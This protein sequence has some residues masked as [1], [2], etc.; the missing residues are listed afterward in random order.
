MKNF[1]F[2]IFASVFFLA[3]YGCSEP[4]KNKSGLSEDTYEDTGIEPIPM[5]FPAGTNTIYKARADFYESVEPQKFVHPKKWM[6]YMAAT[7]WTDKGK[8]IVYRTSAD[9]AQVALVKNFIRANDLYGKVGVAWIQYDKN[10]SASFVESL[11][12]VPG[13]FIP[14]FLKADGPYVDYYIYSPAERYK[15]SSTSQRYDLWLKQYMSVAIPNGD[16]YV[17]NSEFHK[18]QGFDDLEGEYWDQWARHFF[19][20]DPDGMVVDAYLS[21][22]GHRRAFSAKQ[23]INS[24]IHHLNLDSDELIIPKL[25]QENYSSEY[26]A[27]YYDQVMQEFVDG[28]PR[29]MKLE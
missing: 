22:I 24:L 12:V 14:L 13:N 28:L 29:S 10:P 9:A 15:A 7:G 17:T 16:D 23:P 27:P 2:C 4:S 1:K 3:L 20:V 5:T 18:I 21:N 26:S 25:F 8:G 19:V 11:D 6:V